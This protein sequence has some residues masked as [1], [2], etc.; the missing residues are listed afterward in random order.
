MR[1]LSPP[2]SVRPLPSG[3]GVAIRR[4]TVDDSAQW[5][6]KGWGDLRRAP[7]VS[8]SYGL[9]FAIL[10]FALTLG[11]WRLG[12]GSL[13]LPLAAGFVLIG[14]LAAVGLYEVSRRHELGRS[15]TLANALA[16]WRRNAGQIGLFGVALMLVFFAWVETALLLFALLFR[17]PPPPLDNFLLDILTSPAAVPLLVAG[18]MTGALIA[19]VVVLVQRRRHSNVAGPRR[20]GGDGGGDQPRCGARQLAR[21]GGMGRHDRGGR[22]PGHRQLLRRLD[23]RLATDRPCVVARLPG[24]GRLT[25]TPGRVPLPHLG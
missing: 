24:H 1:T 2:N 21:D 19:A 20:L 7:G 11:L 13:I 6:A 8:L 18:G 4:V 9:V 16:A 23:R 10:G 15:I 17:G 25:R 22:R 12:M 14:P 3:G 5:L